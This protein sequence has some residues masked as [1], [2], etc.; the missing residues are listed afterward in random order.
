MII[1]LTKRNDELVKKIQE[2]LEGD[3][4]APSANKI[5]NFLIAE[6][7]NKFRAALGPRLD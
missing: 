6:G 1:R 5:V 7:A 2:S 4:P 3:P